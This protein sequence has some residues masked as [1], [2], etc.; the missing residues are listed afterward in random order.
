MW[1]VGFCVLRWFLPLCYANQ[2]RRGM[3][4]SFYCSMKIMTI[5][6]ELLRYIRCQSQWQLIVIICRD[7]GWT[8]GPRTT[9]EPVSLGQPERYIYKPLVPGYALTKSENSCCNWLGRISICD[10][11]EVRTHHY[12]LIILYSHTPSSYCERE[13]PTHYLFAKFL[14]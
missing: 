10:R 3:N 8:L 14:E 13:L 6:N 12:P 5:R 1:N 11:S 2:D 9:L 7:T 4:C